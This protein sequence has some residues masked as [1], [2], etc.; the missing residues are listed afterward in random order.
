MSLLSVTVSASDTNVQWN[1][2]K[3]DDV[4][5]AEEDFEDIEEVPEEEQDPTDEQPKV[6][7]QSILQQFQAQLM[8]CSD[9]VFA[10]F[11]TFI[12]DKWGPVTEMTFY[13]ETTEVI[14]T[15]DAYARRVFPIVFLIL[16]ILYWTSYLYV[17]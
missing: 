3:V 6:N 14:W 8:T 16:Q 17:M 4:P 15:I 1:S 12:E 5:I 9:Q 10:K 11:E 7:Q 2:I 13:K